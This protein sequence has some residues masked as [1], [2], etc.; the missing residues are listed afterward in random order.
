[1]DNRE[2]DIA[3]KNRI[4]P[5]IHYK[6]V[7]SSD[8]LPYIPINS[9]PIS[10]IANILSSKADSNIVGHWV[11]FYYVCKPVKYLLFFDSYGLNPMFYSND[12]THYIKKNFSNVNIHY[13]DRQIQPDRSQKCGLYVIMFIHYI[14]HFGLDKFISLYN[15]KFSIKK[16]YLNDILVMRYYF[17]YLSKIKTC[18]YWRKIPGFRRAITFSECKQNIGKKSYFLY[19]IYYKF[20]ILF[21]YKV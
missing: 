3:V 2:I 10:F 12:F 20:Y 4:G 14:S 1:M 18:Q 13:F 11:C 9:K 17:K 5:F 19:Y 21:S 7:F 15:Q 16:L 6:G 8:Q